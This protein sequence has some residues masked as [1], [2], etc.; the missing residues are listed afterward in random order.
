MVFVSASTPDP[1]RQFL[2]KVHEV[3]FESMKAPLYYP[4]SVPE[5]LHSMLQAPGLLIYSNQSSLA[6]FKT[7]C[8]DRAN[9]EVGTREIKGL[10]K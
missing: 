6:S 2:Q 10:P 1:E 9:E 4:Q 8:G 7:G 3:L 5:G